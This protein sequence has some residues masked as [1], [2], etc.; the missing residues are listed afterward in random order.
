MARKLPP[1]AALRAFEAAAR[2]LSLSIAADELRI[3]PSAVSHQVKAL[4][5]FVGSKL[6]IRSG[7]GLELT[8][9][10]AALLD[11]LGG[12]LDTIEASTLRVMKHSEEG[13]LTVHLFQSLAQLWLIPY[14]SDFL[15]SNPDI[16]VQLVT[17]PDK[18]DLSG[19]LIDV[20]IRYSLGPPGEPDAIKLFDEVIYPVVSPSYLKLVG[21]LDTPA[22]AAGRR[23]I[24]C[25]YV[26]DEWEVWFRAVGVG[27]MAIHPQLMFD[28]RA[29]SIQAAV[30]ALGI[31]IN[32]RPYGENL[33]RQGVLL[34]PFPERIRTSGAYYVIV[35]PRAASLPRVKRFTAW[36]TTICAAMRQD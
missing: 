23:L 4:E 16:S 32:R 13:T 17:K 28:S 31:A 14:L 22:D 26:P 29:H 20:D 2:H 18:V 5:I 35:P 24:G 30:E 10:G 9:S 7:T 25:D 1:F 36:L 19:S 6:L 12:A 27:E 33:I 15:A 34:A 8:V 11:G 21:P 3:S